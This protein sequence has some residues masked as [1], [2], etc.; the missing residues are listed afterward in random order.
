ML[1]KHAD[2]VGLS[3]NF[4]IIDPDDQ[5]RLLKQLM[6]EANCDTKKWPP[7]QVISYIDRWKDLRDWNQAAIKNASQLK[8]GSKLT[9]EV[10]LR[11]FSAVG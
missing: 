2:L 1:R 10:P 4:T 8:V 3:S 6:E 9:Y 5:Q 11:P 7:R